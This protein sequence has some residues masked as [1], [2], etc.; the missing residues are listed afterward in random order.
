M[1]LLTLPLIYYVR[2][3]IPWEPTTFIFRGYNPYIGGVN[4]DFSW[5]WGP[6]VGVIFITPL[7]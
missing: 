7:L 1:S 6:R 5:F 3:F 2:S 4:L